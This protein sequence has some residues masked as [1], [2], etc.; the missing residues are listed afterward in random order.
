MKPRYFKSAA[1]VWKFTYEGSFCRTLLGD[2]SVWEPAVSC[3]EDM[4]GDR[5]TEITW[6]EG[7]P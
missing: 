6:E 4:D 7:E 3:I 1:A 5:Y 2:R